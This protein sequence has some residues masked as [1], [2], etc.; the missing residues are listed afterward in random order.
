MPLISHLIS[1]RPYP[2]SHHPG[3]IYRIVVSYHTLISLHS[4]P[5]A[6]SLDYKKKYRSDILYYLHDSDV[7][8]T[9]AP[10]V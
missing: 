4:R 2:S 8:L 1:A 3:Y 5:H 7:H 10:S 9:A 6:L